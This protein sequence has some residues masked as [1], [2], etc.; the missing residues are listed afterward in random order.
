LVAIGAAVDEEILG[1]LDSGGA[2]DE[3]RHRS[4]LSAIIT[5]PP[6]AD[7]DHRS[8][9]PRGR[10]RVGTGLRHPPDVPSTRTTTLLRSLSGDIVYTLSVW[11]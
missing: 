1:E 6:L 5:F 3:S 10:I 9:A 7:D 11:L 2:A 8:E 4:T